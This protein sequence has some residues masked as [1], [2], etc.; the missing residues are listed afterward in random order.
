MCLDLYNDIYLLFSTSLKG[1]KL[2]LQDLFL[3][4]LNYIIRIIRLV[5]RPSWRSLPNDV[6]IIHLT[7]LYG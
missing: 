4:A 7:Q 5:H 3:T 1:V 2:D 6:I